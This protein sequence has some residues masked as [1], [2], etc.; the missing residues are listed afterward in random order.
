MPP[1]PS[2]NK[3]LVMSA[4][5]VTVDG[6]TNSGTDIVVVRLQNV[7]YVFAEVQH[8]FVIKG[9]YYMIC[10]MLHTFE[11][12]LHFHAYEVGR[13]EDYVSKTRNHIRN[14]KEIKSVRG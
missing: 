5:S 7:S 1:I 3:G 12:S 4:R 10:Q 11:F 13:I 9:T 2:E 14:F 8:C 6:Y